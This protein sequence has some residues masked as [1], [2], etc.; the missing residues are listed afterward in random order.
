MPADKT[1][2]TGIALVNYD[3]GSQFN[4]DHI[5]IYGNTFTNSGTVDKVGNVTA[6]TDLAIQL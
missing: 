1:S 6:M 5:T 4:V 3:R 2:R